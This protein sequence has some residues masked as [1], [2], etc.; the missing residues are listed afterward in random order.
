GGDGGV[1]VVRA[2]VVFGF[3]AGPDLFVVL[4]L[5]FVVVGVI[6]RAGEA[7]QGGQDRAV[8]A[9]LCRAERAIR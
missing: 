2:G 7:R 8:S 4:V 1:G 3:V 9:R 6:G 5:V